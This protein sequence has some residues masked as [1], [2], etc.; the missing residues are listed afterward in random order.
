MIRSLVF[1]TLY[2]NVCQPRH[3]IFVEE[4]LRQ[5][6]KGG[7][8]DAKV[9]APV[10]WFPSRQS[11]FGRYAKYRAVPAREIRGGI[12]VL[13]PRHL[14]IPKV[15]MNVAPALLARGTLPILRKLIS[16]GFDFDLIDAHY[17]YPDGVAAAW[18]G[19]K[20]NKPI[21]LTARGTDVNVIAQYGNPRRQILR[22]AEK[23]AAVVTVSRALRAELLRLGIAECKVVSLRNGV[24]LSLFKPEAMQP[25]KRILGIRGNL[26]LSIG[27]LVELKG[28]RLAIEALARE[29]NVSLIVIGE[30]PERGR[31][32]RLALV[33]GV[34]DR[35]RFIGFASREELRT[36]YSAADALILASRREGMPN[37]ILEALACGTPIIATQVGGIPEI[38]APPKAG[39]LMR[40]R[41]PD[42]LIEAWHRLQSN[43]L[44]RS[45]IRAYATNFAWEPT[46]VGLRALFDRVLVRRE[47]AMMSGP[48]NAGMGH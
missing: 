37:V 45:R 48:C 43:R 33:R 30:G 8:I 26:W 27:N 34:H 32:R 39:E 22:A 23:A 42:A 19:Q 11:L 41:T 2:P 10:P 46:A 29:R 25:A 24:D 15:G 6:L 14:V 16:D 3:G 7:G 40:E 44:D 5:V 47:G 17:L 36:Y 1:T 18:L 4:R 35:V 12:D 20:L 21:V 28:H 13:H 9:V 31:L 38:V